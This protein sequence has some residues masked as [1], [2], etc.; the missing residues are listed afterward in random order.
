MGMARL[1]NYPFLFKVPDKNSEQFT[2]YAC[3][4]NAERFY[5]L[6]QKLLKKRGKN[7]F[8]INLK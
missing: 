2:K 3:L 4:N 8:A 6:L 5:Y 1:Q 7:D